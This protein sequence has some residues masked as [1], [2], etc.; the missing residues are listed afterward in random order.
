MASINKTNLLRSTKDFLVHDQRRYYRKIIK[1]SQKLRKAKTVKRG[2]F[3]KN[4]RIFLLTLRRNRLSPKRNIWLQG[5]IG[6]GVILY[7]ANVIINQNAVVGDNCIFHGNNCIGNDGKNEKACPIIGDNVEFMY[8]ACAY[9]KIKIA[10]NAIIGAGTILLHD[11]DE[12]GAIVC[13]VPGRIIGHRE[14]EK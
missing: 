12:D 6:D 2:L 11:I 7:H 13:G 1:I 14:D 4:A 8:G 3:F 9:G 5:Q 10:N